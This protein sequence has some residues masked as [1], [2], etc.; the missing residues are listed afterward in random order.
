[1]PDGLDVNELARGL[2][3]SGLDVVLVNGAHGE[4]SSEAGE[5]RAPA[6]SPDMLCWAGLTVANV[7]TEFPNLDDE[8]I[9]DFILDHEDEICDAM[10]N[11]AMDYVIN[12]IGEYRHE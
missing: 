10:S 2:Q 12:N 9:R 8:F 4:T 11:A 7:K 1:M 3:A 6:P 5:E